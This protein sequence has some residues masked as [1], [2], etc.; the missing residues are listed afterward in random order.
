MT[1]VTSRFVC[2]LLLGALLFMQGAVAAYA[3][4][5]LS[6]ALDQ[7]PT[8]NQ[9]AAMP[10][11]CEQIG[12][13]TAMDVVTPNLC[14]A[15]CQPSQQSNDHP[16]AP[17]VQPVVIGLVVVAFPKPKLQASSERV[18][19]LEHVPVAASPPHSILHCCF[20]L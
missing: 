18:A 12:Q 15:H 6:S 7:L 13:M 9:L 4:P 17:T 5:A 14:L 10:T 16:Q 2:R 20:R 11:D 1:G 19:A 8:A 3:C